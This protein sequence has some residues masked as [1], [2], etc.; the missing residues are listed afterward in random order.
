MARTNREDVIVME[1]DTPP[2]RVG[3]TMTLV[4]RR[5]LRAA[6]R[7][8]MLVAPNSSQSQIEVQLRPSGSPKRSS[9]QVRTILRQAH[10]VA[11]DMKH[12]R[13]LV[14]K[15]AFAAHARAEARVIELAATDDANDR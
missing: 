2:T 1:E 10:F 11:G 8:Q 7:K 4:Y 5:W 3:L 13:D 9:G 15:D 6:A 12:L 14:G